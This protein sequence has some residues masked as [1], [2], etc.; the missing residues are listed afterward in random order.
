MDSTPTLSVGAINL[1]EAF[2]LSVGY[3]NDYTNDYR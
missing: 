2:F 3:V 1:L